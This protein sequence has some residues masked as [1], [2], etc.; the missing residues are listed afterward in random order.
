MQ[1]MV[2]MKINIESNAYFKLKISF[3]IMGGLTPVLDLV[4]QVRDVIFVKVYIYFWETPGGRDFGMRGI[5]GGV[6]KWGDQFTS[7]LGSRWTG[8]Y[9]SKEGSN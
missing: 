6:G 9:H 4:T 1:G 5:W 7:N 2:I 8:S 3:H